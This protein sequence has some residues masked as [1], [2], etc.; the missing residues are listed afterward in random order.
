MLPLRRMKLQDGSVTAQG[1]DQEMRSSHIV[2][3]KIRAFFMSYAFVN[4][5]Q[6][7]FFH[8]GAAEA[9]GDKIL[10][11]LYMMHPNCRPPV[12]FYA[13]AWDQTARV[14]QLGVRAGKQVCDLTEHDSSWQHFWTN[15]TP[16]PRAPPT[17]SV[18]GSGR[19]K[20]RG[21]K[22]AGKGDTD[23]SK[24][25][26]MRAMQAKKD[27]QISQLK[28]DLEATKSAGGGSASSG[29]QRGGWKARKKW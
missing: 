29:T 25:D 15:S 4:M 16:A 21:G 2:Y 10:N 11:F 24:L 5:D 19:G 12:T 20:G 13:E 3:L 22:E 27:K 8:L 18:D 7:S 6:Q 17:A 23:T 9:V 26:A 14:L 1:S 28:R